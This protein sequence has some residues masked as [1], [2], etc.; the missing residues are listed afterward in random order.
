MLRFR[1]VSRL[2]KDDRYVSSITSAHLAAVSGELMTLMP[3]SPKKELVKM[4]Y[5]TSPSPEA[6][7]QWGRSVHGAHLS[8][9]ASPSIMGGHERR[10]GCRSS[11]DCLRGHSRVDAPDR[12]SKVAKQKVRNSD[13]NIGKLM[14]ADAEAT[15]WRVS[16]SMERETK[17]S[18]DLEHNSGNSWPQIQDQS[19]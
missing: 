4:Q 3:C 15:G 10:L 1:T 5:W 12:R 13:G 7:I 17:I 19:S 8:G 18:R 14:V 11:A 9:G 2:G 6:R 16:M